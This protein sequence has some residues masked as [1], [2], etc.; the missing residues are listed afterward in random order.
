MLRREVHDVPVN[1]P[2]GDDVQWGELRGDTQYS[3]DVW[4]GESPP[5]DD[6][7]EQ[8]LARVVKGGQ[9]TQDHTLQTCLILDRLSAVYTRNVFMHT[10]FPL[11]RPLQTS[12]GPPE[13]NAIS[14]SFEMFSESTQERGRMACWP[15][16]LRRTR[17]LSLRRSISIFGASKACAVGQAGCSD[18]PLPSYL[19]KGVYEG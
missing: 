5:D 15:H 6:F 3:R 1:H 4:V 16:T 9:Y 8:T 7:L 2:L 12:A 11:W 18:Y 13:A 14:P 19:V 17:V 10:R